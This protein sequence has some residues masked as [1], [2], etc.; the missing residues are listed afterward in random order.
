MTA[1]MGRFPDSAGDPLM[2]GGDDRAA[3]RRAADVAAA[4]RADE[5]QR[6]GLGCQPRHRRADRL[7]VATSDT[8]PGQ[9]AE[10]TEVIEQS[11]EQPG[12]PRS[13]RRNPHPASTTP[14]I[15][16]V[17]ARP[18]DQGRPCAVGRRG[19]FQGLAERW[20]QMRLGQCLPTPWAGLF[21]H[22][23]ALR[24]GSGARERF[25]ERSAQQRARCPGRPALLRFVVTGSLG[26]RQVPSRHGGQLYG[27]L[28][29]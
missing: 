8:R 23:P 13:G 6:L 21:E 24:R 20:I 26:F 25:V 10:P 3:E 5:H 17:R 16:G 27:L 1:E 19:G 29:Y 18:A 28:R 12:R 14:M 2:H 11:A 22:D 7:E 4:V 15:I 9:V